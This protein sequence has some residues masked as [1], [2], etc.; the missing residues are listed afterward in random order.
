[1]K[2]INFKKILIILVIAIFFFSFQKIGVVRAAYSPLFSATYNGTNPVPLIIADGKAGAGNLL[3]L[4]NNTNLNAFL[5][6][7]LGNTGIGTSTP[8]AALDVQN[9]LG[10]SILAGSM[11]I[12]NVATPVDDTDAANKA[13]VDGLTGADTDWTISG[14][15]MYSGVSGNV[16]IG[17][18][19]PAYKLDIVGKLGLNDGGNSVFIGTGAGANDD[20]TANGNIGI[21]YQS[22]YLNTTGNYNI[23]SGYYSLYSNIDGAKNIATGFASLRYNSSGDE[24]TASGYTSLRNNTSGRRNTG[25]GSGSLYSNTTG[26]ENTSIGQESLYS[27]TTGSYNV[28]IGRYAGRYIEGN[29]ANSSGNYNLFLGYSTKAL[30][31]NDQNEIV[32]GYNTTG[33]GSNSVVLGNDSITKTILKGSIGI[34]TS[35]PAAALDVQSGSGHSILAGSM[36]IGNVA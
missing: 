18:N 29:G 16:G 34:G 20:G 27:N 14:S 3:Q 31:D 10:H 23:A 15:D 30:A 5:V 7:Y 13:Y 6:D 36:K 26:N 32:I 24:N 12:G 11:K 21:G 9:G 1:M 28:A 22:L 2:K 25:I 33:V 8:A 4:K 17:T 19:S 35:T